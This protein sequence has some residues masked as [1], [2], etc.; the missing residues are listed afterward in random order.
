[1]K[2]N[3]PAKRRLHMV[4]EAKNP[5]FKVIGDKN[6]ASVETPIAKPAAFS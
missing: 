3:P 5:K 1:M 4:D 6:T 2:L